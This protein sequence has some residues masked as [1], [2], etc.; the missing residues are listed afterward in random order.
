MKDKIKALES[1]LDV[2][3]DQSFRQ[4]NQIRKLEQELLQ[5][6]TAVDELVLAIARRD[7]RIEALE[8]L[9]ENARATK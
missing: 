5:A 9:L 3:R 1:A 8:Q 2:R 4:S 6:R 7:A